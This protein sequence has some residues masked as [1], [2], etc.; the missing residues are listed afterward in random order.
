[1]SKHYCY[2]DKPDGTIVRFFVLY[3]V[4]NDGYLPWLYLLYPL[5]YDC[6]PNTKKFSKRIMSFKRYIKY[7]FRIFK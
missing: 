4:V 2:S 3:L 7:I 6:D 1:M 5:P